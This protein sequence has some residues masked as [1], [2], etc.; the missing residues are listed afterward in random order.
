M[1]RPYCAPAEASPT[2][3]SE[4]ILDAKIEAPIASQV[5]AVLEG[6][7]TPLEAGHALMTRQLRSER[8]E[9]LK[10]EPGRKSPS[11]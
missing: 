1:A 6:T 4:P 2:R 7:K 11:T 9:T 3:C 8:D 5:N 10:R